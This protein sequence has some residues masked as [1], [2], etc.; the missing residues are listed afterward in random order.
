MNSGSG[1][2]SKCGHLLRL[3]KCLVASIVT[4]VVACIGIRVASIHIRH[5]TLQDL[6]QLLDNGIT[7]VGSASS[8]ADIPRPDTVVDGVLDS[9]L[10]RI[11]L[12]GEV[13]R[14]PEHHGDGENGAGRVDDALARDIRGRSLT[15]C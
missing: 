5:L 15:Y 2:A 9:S 11:G 14:V 4:R 12:F 10:N 8:T 1:K 6:L 3:T 13:E 7:H